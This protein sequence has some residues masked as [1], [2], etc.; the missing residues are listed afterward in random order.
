[1]LDVSALPTKAVGPGT[2]VEMLGPNQTIDGVAR[3]AD[4]ISYEILTRLGRRYARYF[5]TS[6]TATEVRNT[7]A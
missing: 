4:T 5:H 6:E 7:A 1:M 3:D 2:V